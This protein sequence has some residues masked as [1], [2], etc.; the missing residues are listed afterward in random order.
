MS[1]IVHFF[2]NQLKF[3]FFIIEQALNTIFKK[4][5]KNWKTNYTK[6]L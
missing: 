5:K 6:K 2:R 4:I 3:S 1:K